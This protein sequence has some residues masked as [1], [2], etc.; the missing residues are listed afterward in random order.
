LK[1]SV[2]VYENVLVDNIRKPLIDHWV[3]KLWLIYEKVMF[4]VRKNILIIIS[5]FSKKN[6]IL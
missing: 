5:W 2:R 3:M 4:L 1:D 6:L